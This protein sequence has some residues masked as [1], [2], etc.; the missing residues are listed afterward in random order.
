[1]D[2]FSVLVSPFYFL[3]AQKINYI[4]FDN[5]DFLCYIETM[6]RLLLHELL[7]RV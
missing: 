5:Y 3:S 1:M 6:T 2:E 7:Q 4:Y